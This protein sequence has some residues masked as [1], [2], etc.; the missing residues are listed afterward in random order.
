MSLDVEGSQGSSLISWSQ[1]MIISSSPSSFSSSFSSGGGGGGVAFVENFAESDFCFLSEY[2]DDYYE[3]RTFDNCLFCRKSDSN[4][5]E[6]DFD[7]GVLDI[8]H[9]SSDQNSDS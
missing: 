9:H 8:D 5:H 4:V 1:F 3:D 2:C 7:R 6:T